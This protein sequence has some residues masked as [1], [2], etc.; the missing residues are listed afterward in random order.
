MK[1]DRHEP[2]PSVNHLKP[3]LIFSL[4]LFIFLLFVMPSHSKANNGSENIPGEQPQLIMIAVGDSIGEGVQSGDA[5]IATQMFSYPR[6]LASYAGFPFSLPLLSTNPFGLVGDTSV[7]S[8][9]DSSL[10]ALNLA[11]SGSDVHSLLYDRADAPTEMEIDSE[12]D[13]VLFPRQGSQI[14]IAEQ[15]ARHIPAFI[16]CW[17]GNNDVLSAAISFDRLDASQM[18]PVAEFDTDFAEIVERLDATGMPLIFANIPDVTN[19][20]F[21]MNREDLTHFLGSDY[22]L[23]EGAFTSIVAMFLIKLGLDDGS[24]VLNPD[25][26]LDAHEVELIQQRIDIF[27]QIIEEITASYNHPLVDVHTLFHYYSENP[28]SFF[29]IPVSERFLGGLFSLDGVHPSNLGHI[30]IVQAFIKKMNDHFNINIPPVSQTLLDQIFL[31]DP[32]IDKDGD[33]RV[34][35]RF[36]LGTLETLGPF[37]GISRDLDD[38]IPSTPAPESFTSEDEAFKPPETLPDGRPLP[39]VPQWTRKGLIE[40]FKNIFGSHL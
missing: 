6:L 39:K 36:G 25:F 29:G 24:I 30:L 15:I 12:T 13:L 2:H 9:L 28:P 3:G 26:V 21:L 8:R 11:V 1:R 40:A 5:N 31:N 38:A 7:R 27:N 22:G 23:P 10:N 32:F 20:A 16:A 33:G 18:T 34:K 19:M 14:E 17:I 35:G 37:L 4:T